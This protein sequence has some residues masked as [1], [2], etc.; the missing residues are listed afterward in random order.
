MNTAPPRQVLEEM[1]SEARKGLHGQP[2]KWFPYVETVTNWYLSA[3]DVERAS[4]LGSLGSEQGAILLGV[5]IQLCTAAARTRDVRFLEMALMCHVLEDFK[6]D[7]R[8]NVRL[9]ALVQHVAERL[10]IVPAE[11]FKG[12]MTIA[13]VRGRSCLQAFVDR[14]DEMKTLETMR[15]EEVQTPRGVSYREKQVPFPKW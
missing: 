11:L 6:R 15:L 2:E 3:P 12:A 8:E 4:V 14:P 5:S 13:G 7:E 9:L 10:G 1:F